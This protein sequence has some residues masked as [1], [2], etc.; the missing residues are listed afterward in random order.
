MR[1]GGGKTLD[2]HG[3]LAEQTH[4]ENQLKT[5]LYHSASI[6]DTSSIDPARRM[7]DTTKST[8][9][10]TVCMTFEYLD[11]CLCIDAQITFKNNIKYR[12]K[13]YIAA[14]HFLLIISS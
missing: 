12:L 8:H 11:Q 1:N 2:F 9:Q 14:L 10:V 5:L 7:T 4:V 13:D 3:T 6:Q